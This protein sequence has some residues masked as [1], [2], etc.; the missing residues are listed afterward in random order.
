MPLD[1]NNNKL[2]VAADRRRSKGE[3]VSDQPARRQAFDNI[4][5]GWGTDDFETITDRIGELSIWTDSIGGRG[6]LT[7]AE[8]KI[9]QAMIERQVRL[10]IAQG[11]F[12]DCGIPAS[13][14]ETIDLGLSKK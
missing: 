2:G 10:G 7:P 1:V 13:V 5:M 14:A 11:D 3:I 12:E 9:A 8:I 6:K 4:T